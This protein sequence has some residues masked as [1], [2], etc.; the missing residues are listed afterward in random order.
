[1]AECLG[2][3]PPQPIDVI[4]AVMMAVLLLIM[5]RVARHH[6]F[7]GKVFFLASLVGAI[8]WL[9]AVTMEHRAIGMACKIFWA[10][11]AWLG[12]ATLPTAICF[13]FDD[14][15]SARDRWREGVRPLV[16]IGGTLA[17]FVMAAT[18]HWHQLFYRPDTRLAHD[19]P[20]AQIIYDHGPLFYLAAAWLYLFVIAGMA[21]LLRGLHGAHP[22]HRSFF[23]AWIAVLAA[24]ITV[25][26]GYLLSGLKLMGMDP[27]AYVYALAMMAFS[28]FVITDRMLDLRAVALEVLWRNTPSPIVIVMPDGEVASANPAALALCDKTRPRGKLAEWAP[29]GAHETL[30]MS[31]APTS[32]QQTLRL[33][34]RRFDLRLLPIETP[35]DAKAEMGRV[36]WLEDVTLRQ[37]LEEKLAAE[38]DYLQLLMQTTITGIIAFDADGKAIFANAEAGKLAGIDAAA[39]PGMVHDDLF[40][41][42]NDA[43]APETLC[44]AVAIRAREAQRGLRVAF[45]RAD[46][47]ARVLSV[48]IAHI[49]RPGVE[50]RIVCAMAD[51]TEELE[52]ARSL[53]AARDRAEAASLTKS[54]FLANMSHEIRTPLNGVLGMAE[55][56]EDALEDEQARSMASTIRESGA[57]LLSVL[58]DVLDMSKIEAGKMQIETAP[59]APDEIVKR[60]TALHAGAAR[61]KGLAFSADGPGADAPARLGDLHRILQMVHNLLGNAIK[62]TE[63]GSV[64]LRVS[65]DPGAPL[66]ITVQ[67]TGIGMTGE[68]ASRLFAEFEQGDG[69]VA[70]RFGGTGLGMAITK[71]LVDQMRGEITFD[72]AIGR[73]TCVSVSLPLDEIAPA[74]MILTLDDAPGSAPGDD[75][76]GQVSGKVTTTRGPAGTAHAPVPAD[77]SCAPV[78]ADHSCAPVPGDHQRVRPSAETGPACDAADM[79]RGKAQRLTGL[80]LLAADDNAVNRTLL[81]MM[82]ERAGASVH[83]VDGGE[84][85]LEA[86]QPYRFD[87]VLLDISMPDLDGIATLKALWRKAAGL[88]VDPPVALAITAN[89]MTHQIAQYR[90]A[91]FFGHAG[92]PF[93]SAHLI[94]EIVRAA[95]V[96]QG[97]A[98][99]PM[100][101]HAARRDGDRCAGA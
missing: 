16:L 14:Y 47:A 33:G 10:Q 43:D 65:A 50:A 63:S 26:L 21:V 93:Q 36:L 12:I 7:H 32:G 68:Q 79:K 92:K 25:N 9:G 15:T 30:L 28:W 64:S 101:R 75:A 86:W 94:A 46:G 59:F 23:L 85:A 91:G 100:I 19:G 70:R 99:A 84:A 60:I 66:V 49:D 8:L 56:L 80:S 38:R 3:H 34:S 40:P 17:I 90:E 89:V 45:R 29:L 81:R 67:D 5:L 61:E 54:Q 6:R 58:N 24:P 42:I 11:A 2:L 39:I 18:N 57:T 37:A 78:P 51:I 41:P 35:M 72:T 87:L 53:E 96:A 77:H 52:T 20:D 13:F 69:S 98:P 31:P 73:G 83:L 1:M 74:P 88:G 48:N 71:A 4:A 27:T 22:A 62:F 44:F 55:L 82:L 97:T 95:R 76:I